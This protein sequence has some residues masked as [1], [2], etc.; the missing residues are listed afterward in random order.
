MKSLALTILLSLT[1]SSHA[2]TSSTTS[3]AAKTKS[4]RAKSGWISYWWGKVNQH[5]NS[6]TGQWE[7]DPDGVSGADIDRL[8]YCR[9]WYPGTTKV[10]PDRDVTITLWRER[11]NVNEHAA[12]RQSFRCVQAER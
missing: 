8:E 4:P 6:S 10:M 2:H 3:P 5:V 9:K 1:F 11:G 12:T 7:T